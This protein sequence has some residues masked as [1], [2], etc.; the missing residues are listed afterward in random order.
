METYIINKTTMKTTTKLSLLLSIFAL[1]TINTKELKS[2]TSP[3]DSIISSF[4][5]ETNLGFHL[6]GGDL[7][8]RYGE[9][10]TGGFGLLYKTKKNFLFGVEYNLLF[11]SKVKIE[12]ELFKNIMTSEGFVIDGDGLYAEIYTYERG[13]HTSAKVGK[14]FPLFG[15]NDNC[16]PFITFGVGMLQHRIKIVN[17]DNTAPAVGVDFRKGYDRMT[18]GI[19]LHQQIGYFNIGNKKAFSFATSFESIQAFT[20][21]RRPYQYDLMG[22]EENKTRI[23]L[24]FGVRLTWMVPIYRQASDGFYYN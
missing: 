24:M 1:I 7:A 4:L 11:G 8:K 6:P 19:S 13:F 9:S 14:I 12:E 10:S 3:K 18:S 16:G 21:P 17:M 23:D 2:Q 22:P 20:L 5:I 15:P